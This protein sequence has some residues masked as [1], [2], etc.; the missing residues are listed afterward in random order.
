MSDHPEEADEVPGT[1]DVAR[2]ASNDGLFEL[3]FIRRSV[4]GDDDVVI[5][6]NT[7]GIISLSRAPDNQLRLSMTS[8]SS[9]RS[10]SV[11]LTSRQGVP[12]R[13][14]REHTQSYSGKL[15]SEGQNQSVRAH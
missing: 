11:Q 15:L 9:W 5:E 8:P 14:S 1:V 7:R 3:L 4:A 2:L 6:V 10:D 12:T 13:T